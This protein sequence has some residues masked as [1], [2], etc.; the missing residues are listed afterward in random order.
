[1][2][3]TKA[4]KPEMKEYRRIIELYERNF[5]KNER[6]ATEILTAKATQVCF[7]FTAYY[8]ENR[9][10]GF[11]FA[12]VTDE[13][14]FLLYFAVAEELRSRGYGSGILEKLTADYAPRRVM[15]NCEPADQNADNY[16]QRLKRLAFYERNGLFDTGYRLLDHGD[17]YRILSTPALFSESVYRKAVD[18]LAGER[19]QYDMIRMI[20]STG[21]LCC[22]LFE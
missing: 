15:L 17:E 16:E 13:A 22:T 11:T 10:I 7:P 9:F 20:S 3:T 4:V 2:L 12:S 14:V 18:Q 19:Y 21:Q 1:M 8:D 6:I 5:P